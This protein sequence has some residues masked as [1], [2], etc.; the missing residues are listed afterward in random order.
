ML[1]EAILWLKQGRCAPSGLLVFRPESG[2]ACPGHV[3]DA[4]IWL[5][6]FPGRQ[7]VCPGGFVFFEHCK[8]SVFCIFACRDDGCPGGLRI[9]VCIF[10][11]GFNGGM[12]PH[13]KVRIL[14]CIIGS[15]WDSP[16]GL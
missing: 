7:L 13:G 8:T 16:Q 4:N 1:L 11:R 9:F 12:R 5:R 14:G 10:P 6:I 3:L 15:L 2:F